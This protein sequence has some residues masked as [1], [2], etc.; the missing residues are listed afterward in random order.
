MFY[1]SKAR[2]PQNE[3][4]TRPSDTGFSVES[5]K[6]RFFLRRI[7]SNAIQAH[8]AQWLQVRP[9]EPNVICAISKLR[10]LTI[11][12]DN[13]DLAVHMLECRAGESI[14]EI[15]FEIAA[16]LAF[17]PALPHLAST[18][19]GRLRP[20]SRRTALRSM[21]FSPMAV[22]GLQGVRSGTMPMAATLIR[23]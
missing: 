9:D 14:A 5:F 15:S 18:C 3:I 12:A 13:S 10:N 17:H 1:A 16:I 7:F 21:T 22:S 8:S 20:G 4:M 19:L 6:W 23:L 11:A 2:H